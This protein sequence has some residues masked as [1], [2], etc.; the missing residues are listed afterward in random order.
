MGGCGDALRNTSFV[1]RLS[2]LLITFIVLMA[3]PPARADDDYKLLELGG[4]AVKWGAPLTGRGAVVTYRIAFARSPAA[5]HEN[6][7]RTTGLDRLLA[8]AGLGR[9][10]FL[11]AA[12]RAFGLWST[13]ANIR[14]APAPQGRHADITIA[15]EADA[16]GIA[17]SDVTP[18]PSPSGP[19]AS[20]SRAI[21]CLN[22]SA[23]WTTAET[24]K[25]RLTYVLAH[26][27]GHAIGLDH[28]GPTGALMSFEY[29]GE[30]SGLAAGD[31]AGATLLYGT[32]TKRR[33]VSEVN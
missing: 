12:D 6:C 21:V 26:E 25:Y 30:R 15:A 1:Y 4:H 7:K 22:P 17:Y 3:A 14:F 8:G 23:P 16:D 11:R 10:D 27:I 32:A 13:A 33:I 19:V 31:I 2:C 20:L 28:P 29:D 5:G 18:R 9:E 24:G